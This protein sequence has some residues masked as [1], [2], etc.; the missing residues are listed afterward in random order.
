[1]K[2][3]TQGEQT[4]GQREIQKLCLDLGG[5]LALSLKALRVAD[6]FGLSAYP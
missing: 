1:M 6:E 4:D 3:K 2:D 5:L